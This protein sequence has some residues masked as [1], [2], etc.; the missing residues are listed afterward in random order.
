MATRVGR[1]GVASRVQGQGPC[2]Y[3]ARDGE[4]QSIPPPPHVA[5]ALRDLW[6]PEQ[7][8]AA[9]VSDKEPETRRNAENLTREQQSGCHLALP[10]GPPER[11][12]Q[13]G[14][15]GAALPTDSLTPPLPSVL[16]R[17]R[18]NAD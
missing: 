7:Y 13:E 14:D 8:S 12:P 11:H 1:G 9:A 15:P 4:E 17:Q 3:G 2:K 6:P 18:I 10:P 5:H 16:S